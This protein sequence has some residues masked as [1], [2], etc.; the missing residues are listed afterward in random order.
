[1]Y[2]V[3]FWFLLCKYK[4]FEV[5]KGIISS[6]VNPNAYNNNN[7]YINT[8]LEK[9]GHVRLSEYTHIDVIFLV[10]L[11]QV[12]H[13]SGL[14]QL[15]QC[16]HVLHSIYAGLVHRIHSLPGD[17]SLLQVQHLEDDKKYTSVYQ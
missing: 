14:M 15:S 4:F 8:Y 12:V 17:L 16:R 9:Q 2:F 5:I 10:A 7:T 13:D 6:Q 1:M 11:V 3:L